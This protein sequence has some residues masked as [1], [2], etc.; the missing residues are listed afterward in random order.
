M[1]DFVDD[2]DRNLKAI[3]KLSEYLNKRFLRK[4][5]CFL[6]KVVN[7][8]VNLCRWCV[9]F[10][11]LTFWKS[12]LLGEGKMRGRFHM[13]LQLLL[14]ISVTRVLIRWNRTLCYVLAK[15]DRLLWKLI[16]SWNQWKERKPVDPPV[17]KWHFCVK[18]FWNMIFLFLQDVVKK[19]WFIFLSFYYILFYF[20]NSTGSGPIC[21]SMAEWKHSIIVEN[22]AI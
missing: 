17:S 20:F 4:W 10:H 21:N 16:E 9:F 2:V 12:A 8:L 22:H 14:L 3:F 5:Y 18:L 11:G 7:Q 1:A 13:S 15:T 19:R 6:L